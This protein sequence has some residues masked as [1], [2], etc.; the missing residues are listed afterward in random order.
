MT[1]NWSWPAGVLSE[2]AVDDLAR[3]WFRAL[4]AIAARAADRE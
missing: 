3:T 4:D 2:A 1:A